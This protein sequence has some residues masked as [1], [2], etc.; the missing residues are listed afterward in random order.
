MA[1]FH[2]FESGLQR[3]L[4]PPIRDLAQSIRQV[5]IRQSAWFQIYA[6]YGSSSKSQQPRSHSYLPAKSPR[7]QSYKPSYPPTP[8]SYQDQS[9]QLRPI[10][11]GP[12]YVPPAQPR[13]YWTSQDEEEDDGDYTYDALL[14]AW[15]AVP[16]HGPG[17]TPRRWGNTLDVGGDDHWCAH[18]DHTHYR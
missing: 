18:Q 5:Q 1:A 15:I 14:D 17:H 4:D 9:N 12:S 13:A 7:Q 16:D 10:T 8:S 11:A 3:D 2:Y 6:G